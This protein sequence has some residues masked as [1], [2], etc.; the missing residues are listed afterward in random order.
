MTLIRTA[1]SLLAGAIA[2]RTAFVFAA[3]AIHQGNADLEPW[4]SGRLIHD[5]FYLPMVI[6]AVAAVLVGGTILGAGRQLT[7]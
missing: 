2:F 7:K 3:W 5:K 1:A 6:G 4:L